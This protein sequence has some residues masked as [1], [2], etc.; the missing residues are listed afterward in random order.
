MYLLGP[1]ILTNDDK[2]A[3]SIFPV[4]V[5]NINAKTML[6]FGDS[7]WNRL[8]YPK[9]SPSE[10]NSTNYFCSI[11][12][13]HLSDVLG[14]HMSKNCLRLII[15]SDR[16]AP[17]IS[18]IELCVKTFCKFKQDWSNSMIAVF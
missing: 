12:W 3:V 7:Y 13:E 15:S 8:Q 17:E 9:G 18:L 2:N 14:L 4:N 16:S 10:T 5:S 1:L 6:S 11:H